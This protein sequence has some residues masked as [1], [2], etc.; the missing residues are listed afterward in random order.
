MRK[1]IIFTIIMLLFASTTFA[2]PQIVTTQYQVKGGDT[3]DS[4]A[5]RFAVIANIEQ[6]KAFLAFR[7]GILEYNYELFKNRQLQQGD[8]LTINYRECADGAE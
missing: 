6:G 5:H 1:A 8:I 4:I 3:L 2:T 7:E